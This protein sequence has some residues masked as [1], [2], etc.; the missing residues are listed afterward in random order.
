MVFLLNLSAVS[1]MFRYGGSDTDE[2]YA[3][4]NASDGG[5]VVGGIW[6]SYGSNGDFGIVKYNS[7]G[8]LTFGHALGTPAEDR[9]YGIT[10]IDAGYILVGRT[11]SSSGFGG[12]DA[13][14][15]LVNGSGSLIWARYLGTSMNEY[16]YWVV[17]DDDGQIL[18]AGYSVSFGNGVWIFKMDDLGN[19]TWSVSLEFTDPSMA[20]EIRVDANGRYILAGRVGPP[21]NYDALL[22]R[23]DDAGNPLWS[24]R[25]DIGSEDRLFSVTQT[26]SGDYCAAGYTNADGDYDILLM[27][28]DSLGNLLWI[29]KIGGSSNDQAFGVA[30]SSDDGCVVVGFTFSYSHDLLGFEDAIIIKTDPSGNPVW[31]RIFWGSSFGDAGNSVHR[32]PDGGF[33]VVG[34]SYKLS[35]FSTVSDWFI[36][37]FLSDG[38]VCT[39]QYSSVSPSFSTPTYT[40]N[41]SLPTFRDR[42]ASTNIGTAFLTVQSLPADTVE[43]CTPVGHDNDLAVGEMSRCSTDERILEIYTADGRRFDSLE[44][45]PKGLLLLRTERGW[46][47]FIKRW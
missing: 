28:V 2:G 18:A 33:L 38:T 22:I 15:T 36:T 30:S 46:R 7:L 14:V 16:P 29:K 45:A 47:R 34:N 35:G 19:L 3:G 24:L 5:F 44:E 23:T 4:I 8:N 1:F 42:T 13:L 20:R 25:V 41:T 31:A 32:S 11:S 43:F 39:D 9:A 12:Y 40:L 26:P 37:K 21:S 6:G 17:Q 10:E 27:R